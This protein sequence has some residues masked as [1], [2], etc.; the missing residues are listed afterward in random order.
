[1]TRILIIGGGSM[2]GQKL[3][4]SL[5]A[6]GL[7][8]D[9]TP[10]VTLFDVQFPDHGAPATHRITGSLTKAG[11]AT[12]LAAARPDMVF[13]LAAVVSG[14]AEADFDKGWQVNMHAFW[15]LLEALR[16][17]HDESGGSYRPRIVFTSSVAVFGGPY[18]DKIG[19]EFLCAPQTSYGAQKL[20]CE[21]MLGDFSRKGFV[22]GISIRLPTICV[23]PGKANRAA[24]SFFS[25]IIREPLNGVEA[26]LPVSPDVRSWH[27]SPRSAVAFLRHSATLDTDLLEGRRA[28][29]LPGISLTVQEQIDALQEV[30]G[31]KVTALIRHQP[32]EVIMRIVS[33]WPQDFDPA[34]ALA[35][36]YSADKDFRSIID[37]YIADDLPGSL[38]KA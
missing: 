22:D 10:E 23:R 16:A 30:A 8:G 4:H 3:A 9:P 14:E 13:H 33:G 2:I 5:A 17:Q 20:A 26:I 18:P 27:A 37:A 32:D 6:D 11:A 7:A 25:G 1:M 15:S 21:M 29:N 24:S 12:T 28:L 36:G 19:D 34:R 35:L 38:P 31:T